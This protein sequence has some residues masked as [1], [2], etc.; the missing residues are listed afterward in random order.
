MHILYMI[1]LPIC[2]HFSKAKA[3]FNLVIPRNTINKKIYILVS[4]T[5]S[6][7]VQPPM[8]PNCCRLSMLKKVTINATHTDLANEGTRSE[9]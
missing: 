9:R 4:V 5:H 7:Q 1:F 8:R 2:T 3:C 6:F